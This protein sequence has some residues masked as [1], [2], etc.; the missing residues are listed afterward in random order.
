MELV[1]P[2]LMDHNGRT[3]KTGRME[4]TKKATSRRTNCRR[5]ER[6]RFMDFPFGW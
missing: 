4:P 1:G 5:M 3:W 6:R 2:V